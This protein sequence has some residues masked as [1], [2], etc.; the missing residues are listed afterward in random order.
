MGVGSV[1]NNP[2]APVKARTPDRRNGRRATT[3]TRK[4]QLGGDGKARR[5]GH[6]RNVFGKPE[7][8]GRRKNDL[9]EVGH[10]VDVLEQTPGGGGKFLTGRVEDGKRLAFEAT[11]DDPNVNGHAGAGQ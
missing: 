5:S 8:F 11:A 6:G 10:P 3:I 1:V 2:I 7:N 9:E 4:C